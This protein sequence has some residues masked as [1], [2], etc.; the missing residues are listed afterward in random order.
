MINLKVNDSTYKCVLDVSA[1][2]E[3]EN[4]LNTNP[5]NIFIECQSGK[6]PKL[7]DIHIIMHYSLSRFNHG[8]AYADTK[9][10]MAD[11]ISSVGMNGL[12][13]FISNLFGKSGLIK[14]DDEVKNEK[15]VVQN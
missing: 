6:L 4:E 3:I 15:T 14:V 2:M 1:I 5:I 10:I 11:Y 7:K 13:E 8:L 9:N 12:M